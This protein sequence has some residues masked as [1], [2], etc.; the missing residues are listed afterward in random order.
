MPAGVTRAAEVA[1]ALATGTVRVERALRDELLR[2]LRSGGLDEQ[3]MLWCHGHFRPVAGDGAQLFVLR[4]SDGKDIDVPAVL[5]ERG[6]ADPLLAQ[7][8]LVFLNAGYAGLPATAEPARLGGALIEAGAGGVLGP[9]M[10]CRSCS[11]PS[12]PTPTSPAISAAG[13]RRRDR[14]RA[15]P[16]LRRRMEQPARLRV[17]PA[18]WHGQ[19]LER[20]AV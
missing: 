12:T 16:A 10:R 18:V 11:P 1:G 15:R 3:L 4:L 9:Q 8:P 6:P 2:A 17:R 7:R 5:T 19:G 20:P 14:P 13:R